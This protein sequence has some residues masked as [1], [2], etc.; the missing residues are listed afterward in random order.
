[1]S[2]EQRI[3]FPNPSSIPYSLSLSILDRDYNIFP[4]LDGLLG[5]A[6]S[7]DL[8]RWL[9]GRVGFDMLIKCQ[10]IKNSF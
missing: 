10:V 7:G 1:M 9:E 3:K 8:I 6:R 4:I 2:W 5:K